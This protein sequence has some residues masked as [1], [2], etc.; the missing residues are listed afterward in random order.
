[1]ITIADYRREHLRNLVEAHGGPKL[2]AEKLGYGNASFIVQ[3][4]GPSPVR[5]VSEATARR[6][7]KALGLLEG[8]LDQPIEVIDTD[9]N[10]LIKKRQ[11]A[12]AGSVREV[13]EQPEIMS[14][15]TLSDII[16]LV[17]K[18]SSESTTQLPNKKV[19]DIISLAILSNKKSPE[20]REE[21]IRALID[22]TK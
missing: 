8:A 12:Y 22:L 6:I 9:T 20:E 5:Q 14:M 18:V 10:V 7:E 13:A 19:T 16:S 15:K 3:M 17:G 2:T 1:M 21:Y 11:R 4:A